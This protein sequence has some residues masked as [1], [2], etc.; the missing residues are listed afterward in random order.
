MMVVEKIRE[1]K[2]EKERGRERKREEERGRER[3]REE[4]RGREIMVGL[5]EYHGQ[6]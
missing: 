2:R 6:Q 1:R 3:K 5:R 4:E